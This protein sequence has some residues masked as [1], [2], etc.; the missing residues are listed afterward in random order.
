MKYA[1][2]VETGGLQEPRRPKCP[3]IL[4]SQRKDNEVQICFYVSETLKLCF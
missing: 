2:E 4:A 1:L 3:L